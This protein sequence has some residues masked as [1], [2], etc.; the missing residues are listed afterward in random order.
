MGIKLLPSSVFPKGFNLSKS[1]SQ[2]PFSPAFGAVEIQT[3]SYY[4]SYQMLSIGQ[5]SNQYVP[6]FARLASSS[7]S[8]RIYDAIVTDFLGIVGDGDTIRV[9]VT[10]NQ[11]FVDTFFTE[12]GYLHSLI[13][14]PLSILVNIDDDIEVD[15]QL[16][17]QNKS[18]VPLA[19]YDSKDAALSLVPSTNTCIV[20]N[21]YYSEGIYRLCAVVQPGAQEILDGYG[22]ITTDIGLCYIYTSLV[23]AAR[24]VRY[25]MQFT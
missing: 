22:G 1:S 23:F 17:F 2:F 12:S 21:V 5:S 14:V 18:N 8:R 10:I 4:D 25:D 15:V 19:V 11:N 9:I 13:Q 20:N 6:A 3:K 24:G 7:G 16:I